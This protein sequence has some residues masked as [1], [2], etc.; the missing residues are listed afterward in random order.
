MQPRL[1]HFLLELYRERLSRMTP[2]A[3]RCELFRV[4]AEEQQAGSAGV[5]TADEI[6][7]FWHQKRDSLLS[8]TLVP[9]EQPVATTDLD[10]LPES[11]EGLWSDFDRPSYLDE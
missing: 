11:L 5:P 8:E 3:L 1:I 2:D 7:F 4:L 9:P 10:Y 6:L